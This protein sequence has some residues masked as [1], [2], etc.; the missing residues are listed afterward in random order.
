MELFIKDRSVKISFHNWNY[1]QNAFHYHLTY[2]E[3]IYSLNF[4]AD[5]FFNFH[6]RIKLQI[7]LRLIK[8][9]TKNFDRSC[10]DEWIEPIYSR[11]Q[12]NFSIRNKRKKL[13]LKI[14][15]IDAI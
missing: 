14:K 6:C 10:N 1:T 3:L 13:P 12:N 5:E 8:E 11:A 15:V 4:N 9:A 7:I 2:Y